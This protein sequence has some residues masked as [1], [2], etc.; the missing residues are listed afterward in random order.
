MRI[1]DKCELI[2][3]HGYV[4]SYLMKNGDENEIGKLVSD[5][6][7]DLIMKIL[8]FADLSKAS[9]REAMF[10]DLGKKVITKELCSVWHNK[11]VVLLFVDMSTVSSLVH[12]ITMKLLTYCVREMNFMQNIPSVDT[13]IENLTLSE[14]EQQTLYYVAGYIVHSLKKKY[15]KILK[16]HP[17]NI[18][19][20][21]AQQF[22]DSV[23]IKSKEKVCGMSFLDFT[24]KWVEILDKGGL[25]R[26][27]DD[28]FIFI[29][30]IEYAARNVLNVKFVTKYKGQDLRDIIYQ[31]LDSSSLVTKYWESLSRNIPNK[32]LKKF[33]REQIIRKWVD[34]RAHSFVAAYV[35]VLKRKLRNMTSEEKN[36]S[37][38]SLS[39]VA[40]PSL[41]KTL[42]Q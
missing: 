6:Y 16:A 37:K 23:Q 38:V 9:S 35:Q 19:A 33:L 36:K 10:T 17:Q 1:Y 20:I 26:V 30:R 31:E 25:V 42:F 2:E 22:L 15:T 3:Y 29:R 28:M 39:Q 21:S 32:E 11:L 41:R 24:R 34:I 4:P 27:N 8:Q 5:L 12:F 13:D 40:E 18:P 7:E 14:E